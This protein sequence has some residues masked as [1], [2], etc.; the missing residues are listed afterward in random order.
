[1]RSYKTS[2]W[3]SQLVAA[4]SWL[5]LEAQH[6]G[7][8]KPEGGD[9]VTRGSHSSSELELHLET[10]NQPVKAEAVLGHQVIVG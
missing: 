10:I 1:M 8:I 9:S 3:H 2:C 5:R 6:Q 7:V 4:S